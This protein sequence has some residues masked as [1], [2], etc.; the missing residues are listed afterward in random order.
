VVSR[1]EGVI[2]AAAGLTMIRVEEL[3][4]A[5]METLRVPLMLVDAV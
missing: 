1:V 3:A 4:V 2:G 5:P